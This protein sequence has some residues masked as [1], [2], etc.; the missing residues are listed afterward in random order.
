MNN[1]TITKPKNNNTTTFLP[2]LGKK[3]SGQTFTSEPVNEASDVPNPKFGHNF[4]DIQVESNQSFKQNCS[5]IIQTKLKIGQ[6]NDKYEQEADRVAEQVMRMPDPLSQVSEQVSVK[7]Q[8]CQVQKKCAKCE[9]EDEEQIQRKPLISKITPM[10]QSQTEEKEEEELLQ[11]KEVPGKTPEVTRDMQMNINN[12]RG[13]G[14]PLPE[15][16][17][18]FFEQRFGHDLSSVRV[19]VNS[20]GADAAR[21]INA[22]AFTVGSDVVFGRGEYAPRATV[23]QRLL[24]HE[25]T[26]VFQQRGSSA[27]IRRSRVNVDNFEVDN[28]FNPRTLQMYLAKI[29]HGEIEGDDDSDDKARMI[30]KEWRN[31][32]RKLAA[33]TK[34]TLIREMQS[35]FTGDDDERAILSLLIHSSDRD[36][37]VIFSARG[38][39][40][41][42]ILDSD[43]QTDEEDVLHKFYDRKFV[44]GHEAALQGSRKL[45]RKKSR[46]KHTRRSRKNTRKKP[47][48]DAMDKAVLPKLKEAMEKSEENKRENCG[49]VIEASDKN[50]RITGLYEGDE[51]V[52]GQPPICNADDDLQPEETWV[53]YYHSHIPTPNFVPYMGRTDPELVFSFADK[54]DAQKK[55]IVYYLVN[56][57]KEVFRYTPNPDLGIG[58]YGAP[59]KIHEF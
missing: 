55:N 9:E 16:T 45:K 11:P 13:K 6:P 22:R 1:R 41:P 17:R 53:A 33:K 52:P 31:G 50:Y 57:K 4:G 20:R 56:W 32:K 28:D 8:T 36:L 29:A 59:K 49:N 39:I 10:I 30:V 21:A 14:Q 35:G 46:N 3:L 7:A 2:V 44:G 34:A 54:I 19:H 15:S 47:R 58:E 24:A 25:L 42:E 51:P 26:H 12:L 48:L 27:L 23:G 38:G 37:K 18:A 5:S 43:F 40:D